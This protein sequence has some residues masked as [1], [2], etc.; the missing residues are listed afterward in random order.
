MI[1]RKFQKK[2][3]SEDMTR[4]R[5]K[6]QLFRFG[7]LER[8]FEFNFSLDVTPKILKKDTLTNPSVEN[9]KIFHA[10]DRS[11][12]SFPANFRM[13]E[14]FFFAQ[15]FTNF[16]IFSFRFFTAF[17]IVVSMGVITGRELECSYGT[18][19]WDLWPDFHYCDFSEVDLSKSY[20]SH[21]HSFS[22][23]T[24]QKSQATVVRFQYSPQIDFIPKQIPKEFPN[25]NALVIS[26]SNLPVLKNELF[27][28]EFV[29]LEFLDLASMEIDS[30]E[31]FAF[32]NLKNLKWLRLNGNGIL[33]LPFNLFQNNPKLFYL[34][35]FGN[36]INSISPNLLKNLK[37]LKQVDFNGNQC[38]DQE[39]GC[40][41]CSISQSD[42][43]SGLS[44]CFQN[45]LKDPEC[46]TKSELVEITTKT[47]KDRDPI[48]TTPQ[49]TTTPPPKEDLP[50]SLEIE[51]TEIVTPNSAEIKEPKS[52][53]P[54][55]NSTAEPETEPQD[56][57]LVLDGIDEKLLSMTE[58]LRVALTTKFESENEAIKTKIEETSKLSREILEKLNKIFAEKIN[59]GLKNANELLTAQ[60]ENEKLKVKVL[61]AELGQ[62][63]MEK[64]LKNLKLQSKGNLKQ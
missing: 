45:C 48:Q 10:L 25:L 46:A 1:F 23:S 13:S 58:D 22:G 56:L 64:E 53:D 61:K 8:D 52:E 51:T 38:V 40:E 37:Q 42:L 15:N 36:L 49:V 17:L 29:V 12:H 60:L 54:S 27:S 50:A 59:C 5:Q 4:K 28:K 30:I 31:P 44:T 14:E 62:K 33:S 7:T 35:F 9:P 11:I 18:D 16:L 21:V 24:S 20:E 26:V 32:Q 19:W 43:D 6:I 3:G 63:K 47:E 39:F 55:Q 34:D 2:N 57:K 41:T